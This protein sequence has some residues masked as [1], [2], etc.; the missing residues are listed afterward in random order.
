VAGLERHGLF[1]LLDEH[2][3]VPLQEVRQPAFVLGR[4]VL[5]DHEGHVETGRQRLEEG[6]QRPDPAGR[7]ADPDDGK[8]LLVR[9]A[10]GFPVRRFACVFGV[11]CLLGAVV[12]GGIVCQRSCAGV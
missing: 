6:L 2:L 10:G 12:G 1:D 11:G 3:G 8:A 4:E 5:H 7:G 9:V